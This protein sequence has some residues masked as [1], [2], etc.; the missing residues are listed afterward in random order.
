MVEKFCRKDTEKSHFN[1]QMEFRKKSINCGISMSFQVTRKTGLVYLTSS[2]GSPT[3]N[4]GINTKSN[5]YYFDIADGHPQAN[6]LFKQ[7]LNLVEFSWKHVNNISNY[8]FRTLDDMASFCRNLHWNGW[9]KH[10]TFVHLQPFFDLVE[11]STM[12]WGNTFFFTKQQK[13]C[14]EQALDRYLDTGHLDFFNHWLKMIASETSPRKCLGALFMQLRKVG[15]HL[16]EEALTS[17]WE[18]Y[19]SLLLKIEQKT[20]VV[21][22]FD[23][24]KISDGFRREEIVR[25]ILSQDVKPLRSSEMT[26]A[27]TTKTTENVMYLG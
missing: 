3:L 21:F 16:S 15:R 17:M 9:M 8:S 5:R 23:L 1:H 24:L 14:L 10:E 2:S 25:A 20:H 7:T 26:S 22:L 18:S 6:I 13:G 12:I 27:K 4:I 19:G 11:K